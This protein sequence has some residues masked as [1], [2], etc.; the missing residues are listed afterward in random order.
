M[1]C[2]EGKGGGKDICWSIIEYLLFRCIQAL[3]ELEEL[4]IA[5][6]MLKKQ[7]DIVSTIHRICKY[8]G[9]S[10]FR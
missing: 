5:P 9:P 6:L 10:G 7:P 8:I 2:I 3:D 1:S 4:G